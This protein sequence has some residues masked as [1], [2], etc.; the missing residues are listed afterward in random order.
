MENN[1]DPELQ[2][3]KKPE[4]TSK[5]Q[6]KTAMQENTAVTDYVTDDINCESVPTLVSVAEEILP[7]DFISSPSTNSAADDS[8]ELIKI[9]ERGSK[10]FELSCDNILPKTNTNSVTELF[11][12]E[13]PE[14]VLWTSILTSLEEARDFDK[15]VMLCKE[16]KPY[17]PP[18][19]PRVK[20]RFCKGTDRHD[21]VAESEI[22]PNGPKHLYAVLTD[23]DGNCLGC[24]VCR[25]YFNN[26]CHIEFRARVAIEGIL[27]MDHYLSDD[28]LEPGATVTH[29]NADLPTVFTT[30]SEYYTPGQRLTTDSIA[31]IY[32]L[33][34]QS[35][36]K[37][38]TYMGLWQLAQ[39]ASV[40]GVPIHT[41]YPAHGQSTIRNDFN[42]MFLP[43][44]YPP[45]YDDEPVVIMWTAMTPGTAPVHFVP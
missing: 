29:S 4:G 43:I 10:E 35:I 42:R 27:N 9:C 44:D 14:S 34:I 39:A 20:T 32:A 12:R 23:G 30:F 41:I 21:R 37:L 3:G 18:L 40:L 15:L 19:K 33:E 38:G 5:T 26:V 36:C 31:A 24:S 13:I 1:Q 8:I 7:T 22:P 28:C 17:L 6:A 2:K 16:I 25:S 45:D 11:Q